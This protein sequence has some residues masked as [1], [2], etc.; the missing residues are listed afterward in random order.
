MTQDAQTIRRLTQVAQRLEATF[1]GK[2]ETIRLMLIAIVAGEHMV[3]VGPPGTAKS[4]IIRLFAKL[5]Q[6]RY[7][8]YLL[9]R[10]TEPNEIFGPI[11]I[12]AFRDGAYKRRTEGMMPESEIVF[13]DEVF[14]ANSAILNSL[15]SVL[16]ERVYTVGA[17][18]VRV[19]LISAFAASNEVPND[20]NLMAVFDRFLLRVH[21]DNLDSY[22][23]HDLLLKGVA[24]EVGKIDGS[25]DALQPLLSAA[26]LHALHKGFAPRM[27]FTEDFLAAYKGLV[28]Q[29]R[30]EGVS[31]SDRRA[32]KMLK[33]FAAS[34]ALDGRS[35][36]DP[37]DFFVL[38]HTWNN[39][40]QAEILDGVVGP[41]LEAWYREHPEA[42]RFGATDVGIEALIAELNRIRDLLTSDRP[43]SDIQL[44]SHLKALNEIKAALESL[45]T[46]PAR[47]AL[48][49]VE[50][51][52]GHVFQSGKFAQ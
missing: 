23:F 30:S 42:R 18:V 14:K 7:F 25:Y 40:D 17:D 47:D 38:R 26:D 36:P 4:A 35:T 45:G 51:L 3:L 1:L 21:S 44:F 24:H 49:R 2:S 41:V 32:I 46:K 16:N 11:D 28:F 50:Q 43:M 5:V 34:A 27:N 13:L 8:E 33:L 9:T 52:L 20:E 19:P 37:S 10:F 6:A 39:L 12:Q 31:L 22:H 15:L 29:I 48:T